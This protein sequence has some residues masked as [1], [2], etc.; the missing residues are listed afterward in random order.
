MLTEADIRE[1]YQVGNTLKVVRLIVES[2]KTAKEINN[3]TGIGH[4][5]ISNILANLEAV[6]ALEY[7]DNKWKI[8]AEGLGVLNKYY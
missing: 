8:T 1:Q 5:L 4:P 7:Q 2:P 6:K 3:S